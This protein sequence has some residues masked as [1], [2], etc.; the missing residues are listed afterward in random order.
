MSDGKNPGKRYWDPLK[1]TVERVPNTLVVSHM[2]PGIMPVAHWHAQV[3]I[4]YVFRGTVDYEMHGHPVHLEEGDLCIFWGGLPHRVVDTSEDPFYVAIHLPLIHFFRLQLPP[5]IQQRLMRG[6]ALVT[7]RPDPGDA[8]SFARWSAYMQSG[9][10]SRVNHA[11]EELLLRVERIRF[12]PYRL[13]EA[14][15]LPA[16]R[17]EATDQ[18]SFQNIGRICAFVVENFRHQIDCAD[19]AVFADI[20]PKYA[21]NVFKK[22]TGMTLNEY[23]SLLR[24]SYAQA[25]LMQDDAKVL[26]VAMDSGFGS[27]SAFNKTFRK[28]AG[29]SPSE[30]RRGAR[31]RPLSTAEIGRAEHG[32]PH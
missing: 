2:Q 19:I 28:I 5:D 12:D 29:M 26:Q 23:V 32:S 14:D 1:S 3:E 25:L 27:L 13:V 9:E 21:M 6:A 16:T 15:D 18:Q 17:P 22:S 31:L 11:L 7:G 24:L 8:T 30:F 10:A 4:N 20:H